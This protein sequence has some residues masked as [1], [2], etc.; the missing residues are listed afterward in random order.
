M[1]RITI[2]RNIK[3]DTITQRYHVT[4]DFGFDAKM[5]KRIRKSKVCKTLKEARS[6]LAKHE[7]ERAEGL[8]VLPTKLTLKAWLDNWLENHVFFK[9]KT[10]AYAYRNIV[11]NH[12]IPFMGSKL[13]QTINAEQIQAYYT[14]LATEKNLSPNTIRKHHDLF[15]QVFKI[16][17]AQDKVKRNPMLSVTPPPEAK[18]ILNFYTAEQLITLLNICEGDRLE[19]YIKLC[20]FLGIRRG[21]ACGL[22]WRDIDFGERVIF[23]CNTRTSAGSEKIEKSPKTTTSIRLLHMPDILKKSLIKE[24]NRQEENKALLGEN[25]NKNDYVLVWP[26]GSKYRPN[27]LSEL[28]S[29]FVAS[30]GL[31]SIV[32]HGLRHTFASIAHDSGLSDYDISKALGHA[33][34]SVTQE[35][36]LHAFQQ[37]NMVVIQAVENKLTPFL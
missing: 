10:T 19:V 1:G 14:H 18:H 21:E 11:N 36:Y 26:D 20:A 35:I 32:S 22:R 37:S 30:R 27:Y 16:A 13:L 29:K 6:M 9:E 23:I 25:Y 8:T 31:P 2:E 28:F 24:K 15:K 17:L 3:L 7:T 5:N 12:I 33:R 34:V 4:L